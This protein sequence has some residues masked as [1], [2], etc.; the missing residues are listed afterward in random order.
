MR[1]A[2]G[3][4]L[5]ALL[6]LVLVACGG[7]VSGGTPGETTP[8]GGIA[9]QGSCALAVRYQGS[10]YEASGVGVA[11]REGPSAGTG[12]LPGCDHGDGASSDEEIELATIAGVSPDVAL[13]WP[14]HTD[15]VFVR[16]E[17]T[18]PPEVEAL[19]HAPTCDPGDEP[20]DLSGPWLG[21]IGTDGRG[22]PR[23]PYGLE[24]F[25]ES[26]SVPRYERAFL[27]VRVPTSLGTPLKR[28]DIKSS[29]WEGGTI[30]VRVGCG[31][32][33]AYLA[34]SITAEPPQ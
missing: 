5:A 31:D 2:V 24:L 34:E 11:P 18:L 10:L 30:S 3:A 23:P 1:P 8:G 27:T 13:V 9:A 28:A 22:E 33:G 16:R 4:G 29:L 14:G 7:A 32:Q 25:V 20:I 15:V 26:A 17:V 19:L 12:V 21:I 6:T